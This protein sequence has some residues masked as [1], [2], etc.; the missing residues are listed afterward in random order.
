MCRYASDEHIYMS[1]AHSSHTPYHGVHPWIRLKEMLRLES[2]EI[3]VAVVYSVAIGLVSLVLPVA[4]QAVVNTVA[5]GTLLQPL[6]ILTILVFLALSFSTVLNAFHYWVV[7]L[8]QR[9]VFVRMAGETT[10]KLV[11]VDPGALVQHHGP[12][13]VNRF[14]DVAMVQKAAASLMVDGLSVL[15]QTLVGMILLAVYHPW[16]LAFDV[17]LLVFILIVLWPLGTGAILTSVKESKAKYDLVAWLEEIARHQIAFKT[18][19]GTALALSKTD[20]YVVDYL[21]HRGKHFRIL[22]RQ[23][24]G[25]YILQALASAVL[26]GVGGWLVI[27]RQLTLGQLVAAEL[28]VALVVSGFTKFGKHL[29]TYYDLMAALDKLGYLTDLPLERTEGESLPDESG[30]VTVGFS[31]IK[32]VAGARVGLVGS[33]GA[34]KSTLLDALYGLRTPIEGVVEFDGRDLRDVKL[35]DLRSQISL[36][37]EPQIFDGTILENLRLGSDALDSQG[38]R[39]ALEQ[40][41]LLKRVTGLPDGL[42]TQLS[43]GGAPL[44]HGQ[45]VQLEIARALVHKPRLMVLD[46]CLEALDDLPERGMLLDHLFDKK[47]PWTLIV[48][49]QSADILSRCSRVFEVKN[50]MVKEVQQ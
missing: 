5:F 48:A 43:T 45:R 10:Q 39:L 7:E 6:V 50:H 16:L 28:V 4:V 33:T 14:L 32:I 42:H 8:I 22:M 31:G 3:W 13:L 12:E 21:T 30:P 47:A 38:A 11:N 37:R 2:T 1:S 27:S 40:V 15:M 25:C 41:G 35:G 18:S 9:R 34:G 24:I 49:T 29:E 26:L 23:T 17:L 44:S 46:E 19:C 20:H 36:V